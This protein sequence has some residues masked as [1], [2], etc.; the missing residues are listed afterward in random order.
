MIESADILKLMYIIA[1]EQEHF[2]KLEEDK[3]S[4]WVPESLALQQFDREL[5]GSLEKVQN[6]INHSQQASKAFDDLTEKMQS[7]LPT[8]KGHEVTTC[9]DE[10]VVNII[11]RQQTAWGRGE[12]GCWF[13]ASVHNSPL[14]VFF[15]FFAFIVQ[16]KFAAIKQECSGTLEEVREFRYFCISFHFI[17][18]FIVGIY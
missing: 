12:E 8:F 3:N 18:L 17:Y 15:C 10:N 5:D 4:V 2:Q 16:E 13:V 9:T 6:A 7:V 14:I 11:Q 1:Q